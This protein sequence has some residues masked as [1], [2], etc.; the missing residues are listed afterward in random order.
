[1]NIAITYPPS[2][3]TPNSENNHPILSIHTFSLLWCKLFP[4]LIQARLQVPINYKEMEAG[5]QG[6]DEFAKR[7]KSAYVY[8]HTDTYAHT[9]ADARM[10]SCTYAPSHASHSQNNDM[11][12]STNTNDDHTLTFSFLIFC[13]QRG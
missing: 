9:H 1:M 13:G 2:V 6:P 12:T 8:T 11:Q 4:T 5:S 3:C 10:L 7:Y